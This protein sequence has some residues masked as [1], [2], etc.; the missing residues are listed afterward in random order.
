M[1]TW[2]AV[3]LGVAVRVAPDLLTLS[4]IVHLAVL[5]WADI[6]WSGRFASGRLICSTPVHQSNRVEGVLWFME[7]TISPDW[8]RDS[9]VY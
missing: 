5:Q 2:D 9:I 1:V 3:W 8:L 7:N 6:G 4:L